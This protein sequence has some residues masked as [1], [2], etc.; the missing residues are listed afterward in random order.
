MAASLLVAALAAAF[1]FWRQD[2]SQFTTQVA[3][4]KDITLEDGSVVTLGAS[5]H[6]Q[7]A[8]TKLDRRVT[9]TG[10]MA[11]SRLTETAKSE[12]MEFL[13]LE[14]EYGLFEVVLFPQVFRRCRAFIGTLG[15]FVT[16]IFLFCRF[17][18]MISIFEI[19][20]LLPE[21][22]VHPVDSHPVGVK[23]VPVGLEGKH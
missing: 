9:L 12:P 13:T 18:P 10:I 8:F 5:S 17:L 23:H 3:Q 15:L 19:R 7:V 6:I 2:H 22:H 4:I 20:M 16:M 14:D 11:T 1:F 21:S